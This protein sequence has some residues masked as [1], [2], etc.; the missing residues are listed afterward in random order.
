MCALIGGV[1]STSPSIHIPSEPVLD[2]ASQQENPHSPT[3]SRLHS[4]PRENVGVPA[5]ASEQQSLELGAPPSDLA[6]A[7]QRADPTPSD[8][9]PAECS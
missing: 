6:M 8:L 3:L 4:A 7:Y 9:A 5:S 1:F 2:Q